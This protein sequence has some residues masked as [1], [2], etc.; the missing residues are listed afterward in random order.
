MRAAQPM[1][2][3]EGWTRRGAGE[4]QIKHRTVEIDRTAFHLA[5]LIFPEVAGN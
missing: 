3:D 4:I 1:N 2:Q 5:E